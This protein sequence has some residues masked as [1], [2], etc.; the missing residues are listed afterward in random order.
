LRLERSLWVSLAALAAVFALFELTNLD[1]VVQ[2][3]LYL[4][5]QGRW[6]VDRHAPLP[7]LVFYE[8]PKYLIGGVVL[9]VAIHAWRTRSRARRREALVTLAGIIS[10]PVL[11]G[12]GKD[13][14][15]VFCPWDIT[16][17][18]GS[19]PYV[20]VLERF[21][22]GQRPAGRGRGFP[23]GHASGGFA[24]M[25]LAGMATTRRGQYLA[26]AAGAA[27]GGIMGAYQMAKGAHYLS[28]T[29]VT[30]LLAWIVFLLWHRVWRT[31]RA[32]RKTVTADAP[33]EAAGVE[34][35]VPFAREG[36]AEM[37]A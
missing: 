10:I 7:K 13:T 9:A 11:V 4:W 30:A 24:L 29:L 31:H 15:N 28:H 18:G 26:I 36:G 21:P 6:L 19:V 32:E 23:A 3:R 27:L 37:D 16:R 1:L 14:T 12:L 22:P 20:R 17:Y 35:V 5:E 34:P 25:A 8:A 2:D 33:R